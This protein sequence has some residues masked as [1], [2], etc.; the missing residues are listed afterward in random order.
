MLVLVLFPIKF[1]QLGKSKA[2]S[3]A[4]RNALH[5][6]IWGRFSSIEPQELARAQGERNLQRITL[7]FVP[8]YDREGL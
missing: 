3:S 8:A 1:F 2:W 7:A 4:I 6:A 5:I